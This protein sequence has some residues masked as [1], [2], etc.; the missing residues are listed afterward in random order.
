MSE[1]S[2]KIPTSEF[3]VEQR[4]RINFSVEVATI[5]VETK[6]LLDS[7]SCRPRVSRVLV[8]KCH[9]RFSD[10]SDGNEIVGRPILLMII[11]EK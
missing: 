9:K 1:T 5:P 10:G 6:E 11:D 3:W 8:Y 7:S 2:E 4:G